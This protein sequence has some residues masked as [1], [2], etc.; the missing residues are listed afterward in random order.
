MLIAVPVHAL[1][2]KK[3]SAVPTQMPPLLQGAKVGAAYFL[4]DFLFQ[5]IKLRRV[6]ELTEGNLQPVTDHL[7]GEQL[8][9]LALAV[10][11]ILY[12]GRRQGGNGRQL[13]DADASLFAKGKYS[14][15]D[16]SYSIHNRPPKSFLS[17]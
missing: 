3:Q 5:R 6:E 2:V 15:S 11:D 10:E 4:F 16:S 13:I 12:A 17:A 8:W 7:D 1:A 9:I 14:I